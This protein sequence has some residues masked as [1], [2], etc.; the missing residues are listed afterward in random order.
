METIMQYR[1][2]PLFCRPWALNGITPRLIESHYETNYGSAVRQLNLLTEELAALDPATAP[3]ESVSRLKR[4]QS[5]MLNS[6][7]LHELYFASLGGDGRAVP[8]AMA[9]ALTRDFGSVDRWRREFMAL[10][11]ALAGGSGWVLLT[12]VPRDG[13]L[14]NQSAVDHGQSI[15]GGIPILALDM[16]EHAYHIDFGGNAR[17]YVA[18]FMRN[19]AWS[20]VQ[21]RYE[22]AGKVAPPRPLEQKEFADV[23]AISVEEVR[24]MIDSGTP[25]QIIDARPRHYT[26]RSHEIMEGAVW[27]D[28]ERLDD[29]IGEISK[30][31]PV[32]TY[33][34]YGF[35]I[36]CQTA[37]ALR[38]A[39]FDARYM[40]GGHFAWKAVGGKVRRLEE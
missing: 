8:E 15:A 40:A 7:L 2:A 16:Y 17:A 35:H 13:R 14:V 6:T 5:A 23:P 27:R 1:L 25:V 3:G 10:A 33:C 38:Q 30:E 28:P 4:D 32:V 21:G 20:E 12:W 24:A 37:I 9:T 26:T 11:E 18:A 39:G 29:W 36:G 31:Q 22:D 34:V 19:I